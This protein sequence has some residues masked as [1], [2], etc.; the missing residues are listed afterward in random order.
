MPSSSRPFNPTKRVFF[1]AGSCSFVYYWWM[2][3]SLKLLLSGNKDGL[4][5]A[6]S[7][8]TAG[9]NSRSKPLIVF[10]HGSG[11]T[12][13]GVQAW[14]ES[15]VPDSEL[16]QWEWIFPSAEPI[17]YQ[18]NGGLVSSIWYD[19]VGG[20][21]PF[22]PEQTVSVE[23]ST[24][25][26]LALLDE[27]VRNKGRDPRK[28]IIAGFSMGGAIAYQ[29]AA[30]WH[31]RP[32]AVPLGGVGGLSCYLNDDSKVWK[33]L[34]ETQQISWPSTYIAHGA[35]DDFILPE[36]GRTTFERLVKAG[37]PASFRLVPNTHHEMVQDEMA[38]FLR[39]MKG[40]L[41]ELEGEHEMAT[42]DS[43]LPTAAAKEL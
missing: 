40:S 12:G 37:V 24:D 3:S 31:A 19:R 28:M 41:A 21:E 20:F 5:R 39:F 23:R 30:R 13:P 7:V 2:I 25:R 8:T 11:D 1:A 33:V 42:A 6:M 26:L 36:W 14:L 22:Y 17:P 35:D 16:Q 18:L 15:L 10:C 27:Q 29:T 4:V 34:E 32:N 9:G 43:S 38:E